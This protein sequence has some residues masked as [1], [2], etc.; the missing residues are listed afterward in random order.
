MSHSWKYT[1]LDGT[2]CGPESFYALGEG[3][4]TKDYSARVLLHGAAPFTNQCASVLGGLQPR[5]ETVTHAFGEKLWWD[6]DLT[7][8]GS[9]KG[10]GEALIALRRRIPLI[11]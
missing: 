8:S 10:V 4:A 1:I 9:Q 3:L 6:G 2:D 5:G 11:P 7:P